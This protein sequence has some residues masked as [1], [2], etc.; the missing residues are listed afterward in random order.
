[1][2]SDSLF[3]FAASSL[4]YLCQVMYKLSMGVECVRFYLI[5]SVDILFKQH[6]ASVNAWKKRKEFY[7]LF[8]RIS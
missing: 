3:V 6:G 2:A 4:H 5:S 8:L 7:N 1:M